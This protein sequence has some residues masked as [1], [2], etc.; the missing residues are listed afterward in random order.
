MMKRKKHTVLKD[1]L[2]SF[3]TSLIV[4]PVIL[5]FERKCSSWIR[6]RIPKQDPDQD[7]KLNANPDPQHCF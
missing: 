6:I 3:K 2:F 4:V 1:L 7:D 5:A